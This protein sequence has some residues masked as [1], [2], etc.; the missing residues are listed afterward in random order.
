MDLFILMLDL[1]TFITHI[2]YLE[3]SEVLEKYVMFLS[4][5]FFRINGN[6]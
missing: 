1:S 2:Y 3:D 5:F 6:E 4:C